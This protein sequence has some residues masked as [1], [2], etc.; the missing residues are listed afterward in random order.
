MIQDIIIADSLHLIHLGLIK[1]CLNY[2]VHG[3]KD[4]QVKFFNHQIDVISSWLEK[5]NERIPSEIHRS[6]RSLSCLAFWKGVEYR[7]FLYYLGPVILKENLSSEI[8]NHFLLLFCAVFLCSCLCFSTK[9]DLAEKMFK[10][11]IEGFINIYGI[12]AISSNIHNLC[13]VVED[14]RRFGPLDKLSSYPF[15]NKLGMIKNRLKSGYR[16]LAQ[17]AKRELELK[18][19]PAYLHSNEQFSLKNEILDP[20]QKPPGVNL[21]FKKVLL[22]NGICFA[23]NLKDQWMLTKSNEILRIHCIFK[24]NNELM[25]YGSK[26]KKLSNFFDYPFPSSNINIY[27]CKEVFSEYINIKE[28]EIKCKLVGISYKNQTVFFP[29]V[30]TLDIF[31]N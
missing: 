9:L 13:H 25:F 14:V 30:H 27:F 3:C 6:I 11:Y 29:L 16:P 22:K 4:L 18:N 2:W 12:H 20:Y 1:R 10:D 15:E 31:N 24:T 17:V 5:S 7:T 19:H 8:Y 26:I 23:A 21:A 28:Q